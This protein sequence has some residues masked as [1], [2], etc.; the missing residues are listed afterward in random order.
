MGRDAKETEAMTP[1]EMLWED[2]LA[3]AGAMTLT[4]NG[5]RDVFVIMRTP[6]RWGLRD[7]KYSGW[8]P[9]DCP[10]KPRN[11]ARRMEPVNVEGTF[12]GFAWLFG[13]PA[14]ALESVARLWFAATGET[15]SE[16]RVRAAGEREALGVDEFKALLERAGDEL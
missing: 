9:A 15:V 8:C 11:A 6:F 5:S 14:E 1:K 3:A 2:E 4:I 7:F 12:E 13:F 10:P 16:A